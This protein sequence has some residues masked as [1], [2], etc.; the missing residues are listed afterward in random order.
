MRHPILSL[1]YAATANLFV[2]RV[3]GGE[4]RFSAFKA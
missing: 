1:A 3:Q 4:G 2:Q